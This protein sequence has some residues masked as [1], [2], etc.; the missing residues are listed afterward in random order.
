MSLLRHSF[1]QRRLTKLY[2]DTKSS[3]ESVTTA[4]KP[5][6]DPELVLLNR[7]FRTQKDR[8]LAWGL[9]WSDASAAHPN[10]ID[11]ALSKAGISDVVA[12]VMSKI[13]ELLNETES[14]QQPEDIIMPPIANHHFTTSDDSHG[15]VVKQASFSS[16][17]EFYIDREAL[18]L[19]N[20]GT[21]HASNPPPY[22]AVAASAN[23]R[24]IG[25]LNTSKIL[26]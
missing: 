7:K 22:E 6:D 20:C 15:Q 9:D 14:L 5:S 16:I 13:K 24:L 8:L 25:H 1:L 10:D 3:Y 4:S 11:E 18:E 12:T 21:S 17:N 23:S 2:T 26:A 19:S